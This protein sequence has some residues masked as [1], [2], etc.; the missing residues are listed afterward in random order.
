MTST[1]DAPVPDDETGLVED[2]PIDATQPELHNP[3]V[4]DDAVVAE[5]VN[6]VVASLVDEMRDELG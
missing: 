3:L 4:D 2:A 1:P 6:R 5:P